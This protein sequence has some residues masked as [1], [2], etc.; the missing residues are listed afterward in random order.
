M[1][2]RAFREP[3]VLPIKSDE[4]LRRLIGKADEREGDDV[5]ASARAA[6]EQS[7]AAPARETSAGRAGNV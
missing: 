7:A 6:S 5:R 3:V 1:A 2:K 4:L